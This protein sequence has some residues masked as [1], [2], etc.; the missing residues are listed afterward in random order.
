MIDKYHLWLN[1]EQSSKVI[2]KT[3]Q[4]IKFLQLENIGLIVSS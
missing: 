1:G 2:Y 3:E 4:Y